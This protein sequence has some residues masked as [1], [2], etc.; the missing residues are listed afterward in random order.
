ME[1]GVSAHPKHVHPTGERSDDKC[2]EEPRRLAAQS[3][4]SPEGKDTQRDDDGHGQRN[5]AQ[6]KVFSRSRSNSIGA[7]KHDRLGCDQRRGGFVESHERALSLLIAGLSSMQLF[8]ASRRLLLHCEGVNVW[9]TPWSTL[10]ALLLMS[11][12]QRSTVESETA[13]LNSRPPGIDVLVIGT[14][15]DDEV[16]LAAGVIERSVQAGL[17]VE[18]IL[19]TNGDYTCERDGYQR[20]AESIAALDFLGVAEN[21]VHFLGYP[22]GALARL[23]DSPLLPLDHRDATG[24]CLARTGTYA[25]RSAGRFDE[26]TA[27]TGA[28][29]EWTAEA[30][31]SDLAALLLKLRPKE[32]FL[33]H[34]I[35]EHSDHAMTY[36]FFRRA[37][38]RLA[39]APALVHRG[40]VHAGA[41]W[42]SDC[43]Q[44][45]TPE[46]PTPPL[47]APLTGYLPSERLPV[48]AERKRQAIAKYSSQ[49]SPWL[50]S[51]ARADE[52][53]YPEKYV[54][55]PGRWVR[56][57]SEE[58][59]S[60]VFVN[61]EG[62][63]EE[64]TRWNAQGFAGIEVRRK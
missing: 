32:V 34:G 3:L 2:S 58:R 38:D 8:M 1:R 17:R 35:D 12:F 36:L 10:A 4:C 25:D 13:S 14:H 47:P 63:Y 7:M 18:V 24:Q 50:T 22:D 43:V 54:R 41:C 21:R 52:V 57:G 64:I 60:G 23:G 49:M 30:L 33:P 42:P 16:L 46:V 29:S 27:R 45:F 5:V 6:W 55:K 59:T 53:F 56:T 62:G 15:P 11:C 51:F 40:I 48:N 26:H 44:Y 31:T 20:E 9:R 37:I 28:P 61:R 39:I 19:I